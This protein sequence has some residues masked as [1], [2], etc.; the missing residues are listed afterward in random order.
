[1]EPIERGMQARGA[2]RDSVKAFSTLA[3]TK[4]RGAECG[5]YQRGSAERSCPYRF[6]AGGTCLTSAI[7]QRTRP[8]RRCSRPLRAQDW[9]FLGSLFQRSRRLSGNPLGA[10]TVA[11]LY[12]PVQREKDDVIAI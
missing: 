9:W 11:S 5:S 12:I 8:T 3:Q 6:S 4:A 2:G 7:Y 1:M 10:Y